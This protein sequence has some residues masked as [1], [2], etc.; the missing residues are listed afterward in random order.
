MNIYNYEVSLGELPSEI[1]LTFSVSG[2]Q[3][4]CKGC[5][6]DKTKTTYKLDLDFY[7]DILFQYEGYITAVVFLGGEWDSNLISYLKLAKE[8]G[9]CTC[10][11]TGLEDSE[12]ENLPNYQ[13]LINSLTF[14]KTGRYIEHLGNLHSENTNQK[15]IC[16]SN[17][18]V[19]LG[20]NN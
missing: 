15:L 13:E 18:K 16:V 8:Y 20:K 2:C 3:L 11:Y 7:K 10:L 5:F 1:C 6:W 9:Y 19:I 4:N 12:F 14:L 17:K